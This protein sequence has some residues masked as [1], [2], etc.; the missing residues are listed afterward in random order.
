[1]SD[2]SDIIDAVSAHVE[3][4]VVGITKI[5][6]PYEPTKNPDMFLKN[7]Y[8]LGVGPA[9][10]TNR[11]LSC[12]VSIQ[13]EIVIMLLREVAMVDTRADDIE[14]QLKTLLEDE[15]LIIKA[16]ENDQDLGGVSY[17]A[18]YSDSDSVDYLEEDSSKYFKLVT[19]FQVEY[20]E[21]IT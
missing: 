2:I 3:A 15:L 8:G 6:N 9:T 17:Q 14:N 11:K 5:P 21:P 4:Q 20:A 12:Q 18:R 13:R 16:I 1:M 19:A 7:G 10:N